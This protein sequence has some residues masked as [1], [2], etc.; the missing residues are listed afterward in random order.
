MNDDAADS[1]ADSRQP[2]MSA[3]LPPDKINE[4]HQADDIRIVDYRLTPL[5]GTEIK[6]RSGI[7]TAE[8]FGVTIGAASTF[9]RFVANPF[10]EIVGRQNDIGVLNL[11]F[12]GAGPGFFLRRPE[13]LTWIN[14]A[15]FAVVEATTAGSPANISYEPFEGDQSAAI[16]ACASNRVRWLREMT[17]LLKRITVPRKRLLWFS[18]RKPEFNL[19]LDNVTR[20]WADMPQF[21][22][23]ELLDELI[24][25]TGVELIE[26]VTREGLPQPL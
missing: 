7:D 3:E 5:E 9:G 18:K 23:R 19:G 21:V 24:G 16:A 17:E 11:G 22:N 26:V 20:Y 6:V 10:P 4:R 2:A 14:R 12:S 25:M 8:P 13:L 1:R 15:E